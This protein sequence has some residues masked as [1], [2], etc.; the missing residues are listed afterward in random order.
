MIQNSEKRELTVFAVNRS[1]SEDMDLELILE[2]F[3]TA[4]LFEHVE[5]FSEDLKAVNTAQSTDAITPAKRET[6][7]APSA[8]QRIKLKKHSWNMLRFHY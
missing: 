3:D 1:L 7:S 2:G 4:S 6:D 5:L 8:N